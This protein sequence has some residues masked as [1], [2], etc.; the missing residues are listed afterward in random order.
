[1]SIVEPQDVQASCGIA[2]VTLGLGKQL[3]HGICVGLLLLAPVLGKEAAG[4]LTS[5][6][7]KDQHDRLQM[8]GQAC[9][10]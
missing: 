1:M 7:V 9:S 2:L 6:V 3:V 4:V 8:R 10:P 5:I